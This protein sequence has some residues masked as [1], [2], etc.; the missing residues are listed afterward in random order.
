M[1]IVGL[2][3]GIGTGKT[4]VAKILRELGAEIISA[5]EAAH[6]AYRSGTDGWRE[7]VGEFGDGILGPDGEVDRVSLGVIV[8]DDRRALDR[9]NAIV[10]PRARAAVEDRIR[11]SVA[12]VVVVEAALLV[13]AGWSS[14]VDQVWVTVAGEDQVV[15]RVRRRDHLDEEAIRARARTQMPD[16]ERLTHADAVILNT[17]TPIELRERV[18]SL[19]RDLVASR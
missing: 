4:E 9:L 8:F 17:G 16:S 15:E 13:E 5:D 10:H 18:T 12:A 1:L 14:M 2:T 3:G 6:E 19:W 11:D 7:V